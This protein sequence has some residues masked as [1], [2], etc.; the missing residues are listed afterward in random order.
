MAYTSHSS[1]D[2]RGTVSYL[3]EDSWPRLY[4]VLGWE[5][6]AEAG[7]QEVEEVMSVAD[8][9]L[10]YARLRERELNGLVMKVRQQFTI[11]SKLPSPKP[12]LRDKISHSPAINLSIFTLN[13]QLRSAELCEFILKHIIKL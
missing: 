12:T 9:H 2:N 5:A 1:P 6:R 13:S 8:T 7:G 4:I 3:L 10:R 11:R